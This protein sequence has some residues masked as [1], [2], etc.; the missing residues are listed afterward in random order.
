MA[1]T[2]MAAAGRMAQMPAQTF[3]IRR[4]PPTPERPQAQ[5]LLSPA[6]QAPARA[7]EPAK[8]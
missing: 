4:V 6:L 7:H 8:W 2:D 5:R 1:I 3:G